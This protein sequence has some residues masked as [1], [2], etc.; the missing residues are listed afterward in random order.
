MS[1]QIQSQRSFKEFAKTKW[2]LKFLSICGIRILENRDA[3]PFQE[4]IEDIKTV[5]HI[6]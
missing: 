5:Y 3:D 4:S 2:I 6:L 1:T